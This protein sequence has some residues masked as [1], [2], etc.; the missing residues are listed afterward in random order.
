MMAHKKWNLRALR[1]TKQVLE[2]VILDHCRCAW[3]EEHLN[4]AFI[5]TA[6]H[7]SNLCWSLPRLSSYSI[8]Y[9]FG[10]CGQWQ[11]PSSGVSRLSKW[12]WNTMRERWRPWTH[13]LWEPL[14]IPHLVET[15]A[16]P[17]RHCQMC[18]SGKQQQNVKLYSF[19]PLFV[20]PR[21][22]IF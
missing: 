11:L 12:L 21:I 1:S 2:M 8:Y 14:E 5:L 19:F 22:W 6:V 4:T 10:R 16:M 20:P 17:C 18:M 13:L 3:S 7:C 15:F 9:Q